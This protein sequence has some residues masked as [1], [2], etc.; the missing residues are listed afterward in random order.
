MTVLAA[1][2]LTFSY[3]KKTVLEGIDLS[4]NRGEVLGILGQ[5]GSGKTTL[6]R[7]LAGYLKPD[8]G[9]VLC[10]GRDI[11]TMGGG[12]LA[13]IRAVVGQSAGVGFDFP[14]AEFVMLGRTPYLPRFGRETPHDFRMV[15]QALELTD[16]GHLQDRLISRLSGGEL[17]RVTIARALAQEPEILMLDEPTSHLDVRHQ[18]EIMDLLRELSRSMTVVTIVHD[19]NSAIRHCDRVALLHHTRLHSCGPPGE[20]LIPEA[21]REV[22]AVRATRAETPDTGGSLLS[23][24]LPPPDPARR[25]VHIHVLS[26]GGYG[27]T[28]LHALAGRGYQVSAGVLNEGDLDLEVARYLGCRVVTA[29]PFSRIGEDHRRLL[30]EICRDAAAVVVVAMPVGEGNLENLRFARDMAQRVPVI[31]YAPACTLADLD[32]TGGEAAALYATLRR[33]APHAC[34]LEELLGRLGIVTARAEGTALWKNV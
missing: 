5:N 20:V 6:L 8:R 18:L 24:S 7:L 26:G 30:E 4:C 33:H 25:D 11:A 10:R 1:R 32:Y 28:V 15:E 19:L 21:I 23:F 14:V 29:P 34:S 27:R 2:D 9:T 13:R 17:Q 22:F 31:L 12:D 3:G 16:T